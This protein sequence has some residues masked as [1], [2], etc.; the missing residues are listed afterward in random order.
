MKPITIS[1]TQLAVALP[2]VQPGLQKYWAIQQQV[3]RDRS[4]FT[5]PVLRRSYNGFYRVRR[6]LQWQSTY[7]DL[8]RQA[9]THGY[10]FSQVLRA[11]HQ[12]TGRYEA[13]FASKLIATLDTT[14][15]VIDSVVLSN[16][17]CKLASSS[18]P[19]RMQAIESLH[20]DLQQN[21]QGFLASAEGRALVSTFKAAYPAFAISEEKMVD[22]VLWQ[23]R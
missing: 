3:Q 10:G 2:K 1:N 7:F 20:R 19:N 18:T 12:S 11:L 17:G 8:M 16:L 4:G 6:G 22:L 14:Q 21:F 13:S 9:Q 15:P 5:D 23:M